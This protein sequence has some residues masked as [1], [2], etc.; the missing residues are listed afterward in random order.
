[1]LT[2]TTGC[3]D[4]LRCTW[5]DGSGTGGGGTSKDIESPAYRPQGDTEMWMG[6]WSYH[7]IH[8]S[9]NKKEMKT[10][11]LTLEQEYEA[12]VAKGLPSNVRDMTMIYFTDNTT[13]YYCVTSGSSCNYILHKMVQRIKYLEL[14]LGCHLE[15]IHVPGTTMIHQG[16]DG[17]TR[18]V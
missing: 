14:L 1:M 7:V 11:V 10:R 16:T 18:R 3:T 6:M 4:T 2:P 8:Y 15:V 12:T 5:G 13:V 9:S 17:L